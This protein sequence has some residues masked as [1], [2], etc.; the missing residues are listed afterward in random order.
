M[1]IWE[2]GVFVSVLNRVILK[3][4]GLRNICGGDCMTDSNAFRN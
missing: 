1:L 4:I 3:T 2:W